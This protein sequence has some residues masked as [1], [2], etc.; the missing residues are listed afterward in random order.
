M[1]YQHLRD[2]ITVI[3]DKEC[4]KGASQEEVRI[5][6]INLGVTFPKSFRQFL[7]EYGWA[8]FGHQ[9]LY[10]LG[11]DVPAYLELIRNTRAEREKMHPFLLPDLV[12]LMNDG[13]GNHYCLD[14]RMMKEGECPVV[15]WNHELGENQ[16]P[17]RVSDDFV[18][19]IIGILS[20][21]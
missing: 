10:G 16:D 2:K 9:E 20:R 7:N 3:L 19:W 14:T 4:G 12:P 15:F 5:A 17:E 21:L 13:A 8:R 18:N 6:E 11:R 1:A